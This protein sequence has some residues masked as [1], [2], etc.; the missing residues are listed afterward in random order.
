MLGMQH[1]HRPAATHPATTRAGATYTCVMHAQ[2]SSDT[3]GNCPICGMKLQLKKDAKVSS[4][5]G[6]E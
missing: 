2:V 4:S 5:G 3:P 6:H 1:D